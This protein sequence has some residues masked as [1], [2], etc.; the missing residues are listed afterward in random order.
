YDT[1]SKLF[2]KYQ[3][4][5]ELFQPLDTLSDSEKAVL[6]A[7][8]TQLAEQV[9]QLRNVLNIDVYYYYKEAYGEK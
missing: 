8:I 5:E 9:A 1:I 4:D 6:F 7:Q 2:L 3:R